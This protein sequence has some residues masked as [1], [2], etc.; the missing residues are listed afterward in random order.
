M[1][2]D[3]AVSDVELIGFCVAQEVVGAVGSQLLALLD[4]GGG[5]GKIMEGH[6][7]LAEAGGGEADGSE[8]APAPAPPAL[9]ARYNVVL[10]AL[11][12]SS[13]AAAVSAPALQAPQHPLPVVAAAPAVDAAS[14]AVPAFR[15]ADAV[16]LI[17]VAAAAADE[18]LTFGPRR[19]S[20]SAGPAL[21]PRR[22]ST[23]SAA[24]SVGVSA[25]QVPAAPAQQPAE[26]LLQPQLAASRLYTVAGSD[27]DVAAASA[28]VTGV[29]AEEGQQAAAAAATAVSGAAGSSNDGA[30]R[31]PASSV[32]ADGMDA[33]DLEVRTSFTVIQ[34]SACFSMRSRE[35]W[36]TRCQR[37][38][39]A[40]PKDV[41]RR[42]GSHFDMRP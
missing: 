16:A 10:P 4:G 1:L 23:F 21:P 17:S 39:L 38:L 40:S 15:L 41:F 6:S 3:G 30:R 20:N 29:A 8:D 22:Q 32:T 18:R 27:T 12:A 14:D 13:A 37:Q 2:T 35:T 7:W 5:G 28:P 31:S 19:R 36:N 24:S 42:G 9:A 26:L 34:P 25:V 11:A 33:E